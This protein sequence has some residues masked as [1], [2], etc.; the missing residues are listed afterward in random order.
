MSL[1]RCLPWLLLGLLVVTSSGGALAQDEGPSAPA[2]PADTGFTYQ[3]ELDNG[4]GPVT[5]A[6]DFQFKLFDAV[7]SGAQVGATQTVTSVS[8]TTALTILE[9]PVRS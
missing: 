7:S 5:G 4:K 3:G 6:C 8:E 1:R 9:F 2:G